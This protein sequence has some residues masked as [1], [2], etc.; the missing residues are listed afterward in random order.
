M[1]SAVKLLHDAASRL[2]LT[3]V[4]GV[5]E[6]H[7]SL[8]HTTHLSLQ[9]VIMV[10]DQ[11]LDTQAQTALRVLS[12]FPPKPNTFSEEAAIAVCAVPGEVL[13]VLA[14]A[15]LLESNGSGR[16]TLHQT[17]FDYAT[18][19]YQEQGASERFITY[20]MDFIEVHEIDYATLDREST[21][22]LAALEVAHTL[23]KSAEFVRM[24]CSL[25]NFW[26]VR[27]SYVFAEEY[28]LRA[29]EAAKSSEDV[30]GQAHV[31]QHLARIHE[32]W[33]N[34]AQVTLY[35]HKSL[36]LAHYMSDSALIGVSLS[37][38]GRVTSEQGN[39]TLA[40]EYNLEGLRVAR[41]I[42]DAG[43]QSSLLLN[44]GYVADMRGD[45]M[46]EE[47]YYQEGLMLAQQVG[48]PSLISSLLINLGDLKREQGNYK[49][50]EAYFSEGMLLARQIGYQSQ[51]IFFLAN[52]G[53]LAWVSRT[54][55][56]SGIC[57][58]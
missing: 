1:H 8:P 34:Y 44:L 14:D 18:L 45:Y 22:I 4:R 27:A 12:I 16:Y 29:Y 58:S 10:S 53:Q 55:D 54:F 24:V 2:R 30:R 31:L 21:N 51:T 20:F 50:A 38:L 37:S 33:G 6:H 7:P 42:G 57:P 35:L 48:D 11:R 49:Q 46:Q 23:E 3:E 36:A 17:I 47:A 41:A 43:L 32:Q 28:L 56:D 9:S 13:D 5:V 19:H 26:H 15:G 25:A 39:Y 40:E 52:F